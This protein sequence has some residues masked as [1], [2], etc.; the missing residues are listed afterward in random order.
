MYDSYVIKRCLNNQMKLC[1]KISLVSEFVPQFHEQK[2][3]PIFP[4]S[5]TP[6]SPIPIFLRMFDK[7]SVS[8]FHQLLL[9]FLILPKL[10]PQPIIHNLLFNFLPVFLNGIIFTLPHFECVKWCLGCNY[11]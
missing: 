11:L 8:S 10:K 5:I 1:E 4:A 6:I 7:L 2:S 9:N 3:Q